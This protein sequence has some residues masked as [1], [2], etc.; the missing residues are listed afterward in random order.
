M[1]KKTKLVAGLWLLGCVLCSRTVFAVSGTITKL[2]VNASGIIYFS[3]S[4]CPYT[5]NQ[6]SIPANAAGN[7]NMLAM[8]L[9]AKVSGATV[10]VGAANGS[11]ACPTATTDAFWVQID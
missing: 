2:M 3:T 1:S 5:G 11:T 4:D 8:L 7:R 9:S 6:W 10:H